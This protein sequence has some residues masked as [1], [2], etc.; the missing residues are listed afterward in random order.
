[1]AGGWAWWMGKHRKKVAQ[2]W[3][4]VMVGYAKIGN[5]GRNLYRVMTW[6]LR[7]SKGGTGNGRGVLR[8]R[9]G[10][11]TWVGER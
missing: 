4:M 8:G 11:V 9:G 7:G 6:R 3:G 10:E 1:M 2:G 5:M